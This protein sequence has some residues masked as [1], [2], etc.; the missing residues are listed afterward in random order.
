MP[1]RVTL[2][3]SII[4]LLIDDDAVDRK[5][6]LR[7]LSP[8]RM[9]YELH[10]ASDGHTGI[11]L[12][13]SKTF[14]CIVLDYNLPDMNGLELL[15]QLRNDEGILV[16][17]VILTGS[18]NEEVAVESM[19]RGAHDY[20]RKSV[21]EPEMLSRAVDNAI[22]KSSQQHKL[23][24]AHHELHRKALYD[25]LTGLGNRNLFFEHLTL[26]IAVAR[27]EGSSF[28]LLFMDL[29]AFKEANDSFG[30]EA[31]DAILTA[32][33]SRLLAISRSADV[34]FRI[35]GDEFTAILHAGSDG[36]AAARRV[37]VAVAEPFRLGTTVLDVGISIG[38]ANFPADGDDAEALIGSADGAMYRAKKAEIGWASASDGP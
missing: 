6:V 28:P 34:Y 36:G 33:G 21:L 23:V 25:G 32:I 27:R 29:N 37:V 1:D 18:G 30:H 19:K 17:V 14:D 8:F 22:A 24:V 13:R 3:R 35:G 16:P 5:A 15:D 4:L 7:A 38:V 11:A 12:A 9:K 26:A 31:G 10:E 2:D 20:I